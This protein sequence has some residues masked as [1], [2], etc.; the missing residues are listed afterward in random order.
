MPWPRQADEEATLD[1]NLSM[2]S[3]SHFAGLGPG[4]RSGIALP[5]RSR[6]AGGLSAAFGTGPGSSEQPLDNPS[7]LSFAAFS[8]DTRDIREGSYH[9][10]SLALS[11][12]PI[13]PRK[14]V[15]GQQ[16]SLNHPDPQQKQ[17]FEA[18]QPLS[19]SV[20]TSNL[21]QL[22]KA[23]N[24]STSSSPESA[25]TTPRPPPQLLAETNEPSSSSDTQRKGHSP[26]TAATPPG[27][28]AAELS[29]PTGISTCV[30]FLRATQHQQLSDENT[31]LLPKVTTI[32]RTQS[33]SRAFANVGDKLTSLGRACLPLFTDA[34][35]KKYFSATTLWTAAK[36]PLPYLPSTLLGILMNL[37]DGVS[38]GLYASVFFFGV[39]RD[40]QLTCLLDL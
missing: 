16:A 22:L 20:G 26:P 7:S 27:T 37:L 21:A 24:V 12:H 36:A 35:R 5:T 18:V 6:A 11:E 30:A 4:P 38:Y 31:P 40:Q 3:D 15:P 32:T 33:T 25:S 17:S 14:A 23:N 8:Q 34:K 2:D 9:L 13:S 19:A 29:A 39:R 10:G 1:S 28:Q